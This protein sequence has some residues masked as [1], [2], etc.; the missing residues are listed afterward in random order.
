MSH[1]YNMIALLSL[2]SR[3]SRAT[4]KPGSACRS[5][6]NV[7]RIRQDS[8][9]VFIHEA[10]VW[11]YAQPLLG[12]IEQPQH[13]FATY[14]KTTFYTMACRALHTPIFPFTMRYWPIAKGS[15]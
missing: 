4:V 5:R 2:D 14:H 7:S 11:V 13:P 6:F 12:C 15:S 1:H 3:S 10:T 8:L 9:A